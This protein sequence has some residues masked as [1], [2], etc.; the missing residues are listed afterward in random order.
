[1]KKKFGQHASAAAESLPAVPAIVIH[2][3]DA[4][5]VVY[6]DGAVCYGV[7]NSVVMIETVMDCMVPAGAETKMRKVVTSHLRMSI[8]AA[9]DLANCIQQALVGEQKRILAAKERAVSPQRRTEHVK[10]GQ[11]PAINSDST[12]LPPLPEEL[13]QDADSDIVN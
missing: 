11:I 6:T 4:A 1:M 9:I 7:I 2:G 3:T 5:P 13:D 12:G 8:P 10:P